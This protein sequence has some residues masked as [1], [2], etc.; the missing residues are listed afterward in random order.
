MMGV[1]PLQRIRMPG[2]TMAEACERM[3]NSV[4]LTNQTDPRMNGVYEADDSAMRELHPNYEKEW[5][6]DLRRDMEA[7]EPRATVLRCDNCGAPLPASHG[8]PEVACEY[9]GVVS[10]VSGGRDM[11]AE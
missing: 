3:R 9:C 6:R 8:A 10:R 4:L 7:T 1:R 11:G 2:L 5:I